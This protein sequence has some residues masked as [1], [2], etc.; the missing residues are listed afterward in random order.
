MRVYPHR[1]QLAILIAF[2]LT[3][4]ITPARAASTNAAAGKLPTASATAQRLAYVTDGNLDSQRYASLAQGPQFIQLDLGEPHQIDRLRLW[5]YYAESGRRY[6]DVIVQVA[7]DPSFRSGVVT[8]F[9]TDANNSSGQGYGSD[10]EYVETSTGKEILLRTPVNAQFVRVWSNGSNHNAWNHY[11]ELQV[12]GVPSL[13]FRDTFTGPDGHVITDHT[14][15][16]T[17]PYPYRGKSRLSN[18][19]LVW[20][21][22]SGWF[23][24]MHGWGYSGRPLDWQNPWFFRFNLRRFDLQD[25]AIRWSYRSADFPEDRHDSKQWGVTPAVALWVRKQSQFWT[26][27]V[28]FDRIDAAPEARGNDRVNVQVKIPARGWKGPQW[29]VSNSGVYYNLPTDASQPL[30]GRGRL[31]ATWNELKGALPA[32]ESHK[33][34]FPSLARDGDT[35]YQFAVRVKNLSDGRVQIQLLR[36]G[37]LVYSV[38]DSGRSGV[39]MD[40]KT[41]AQHLAAGYYQIPGWEAKWSRPIT[42]PGSVGFRSDNLQFWL[43]D[44]TVSRF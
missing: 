24:W 27:A 44:L 35:E 7:N 30:I 20:E 23:Y 15:Y 1:I 13:L 3:L 39:A 16:E 41:F 25:V 10:P 18:P 9:S 4:P 22:D 32:G 37:A 34:G 26:Y 6:R 12:Y 42:A 43:D 5:R 21:G 8:C 29:L 17:A 28:K 11:V 38:T 14:H 33:P 36:S 2:I 19:S 40:G 31:W